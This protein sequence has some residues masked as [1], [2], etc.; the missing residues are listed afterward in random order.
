MVRVRSEKDLKAS[1]RLLCFDLDGTLSQHKSHMPQENREL[2]RRL[3]EKYKL[4][5]VGAGNAPRIYNQMEQF[6]IDIIANYGMQEAVVDG[7]LKIIRE[8]TVTPDK[9][10]FSVTCQYLREKYGYTEYAGGHLEFHASGM[11][12][13]CLLGSG[14]KIED[15]VVFDPDRSKRRVLYD[16]I[17]SLFPDCSVY[18]GGTSSF[19]FVPRR[20][21]KYDSIMKYA[22][23][24]GY[25][26]EEI[27]FVG[28]DFGD[29][30]GDS[31][32]RVFGM[33]YV[34]VDDYTKL[35]QMLSFL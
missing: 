2:L 28:D 13:F 3:G 4:V 16:E 30:G 7:G 35:P 29:G 25:S 12:T 1:K 21:N 11:V 31:H 6:P 22:S 20:Y 32:V 8:D 34:Q 19:D 27:L 9:E 15:K 17:C 5:M 10:Y 18:I 14:A 26:E 23:D 33:D 24:H